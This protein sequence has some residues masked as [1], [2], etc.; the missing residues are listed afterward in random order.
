MRQA[1]AVLSHGLGLGGHGGEGYS[2]GVVYSAAASRTI[3]SNSQWRGGFWGMSDS[4][5]V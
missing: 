2:A 3:N 5:M 1:A 4:V